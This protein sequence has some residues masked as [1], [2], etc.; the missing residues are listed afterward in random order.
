MVTTLATTTE[1]SSVGYS[2]AVGSWRCCGRCL[3]SEKR[4]RAT[5]TPAPKSIRLMI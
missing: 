2:P 3:R 4:K 1:M 5:V